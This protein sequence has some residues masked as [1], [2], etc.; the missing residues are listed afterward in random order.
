[1]ICLG[2]E[3]NFREILALNFVLLSSSKNHVDEELVYHQL[4][5]Q[6]P[7]TGE[8]WTSERNRDDQ[9]RIPARVSGDNSSGL[10]DWSS[11]LMYSVLR[12][13]SLL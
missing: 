1:M 6:R 4:G 3:P 2:L 11:T 8:L 7:P 13:L 12:H 10:L 9:R 5:V